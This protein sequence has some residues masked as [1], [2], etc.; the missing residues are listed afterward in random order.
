MGV[1]PPPIPDTFVALI[2]MIS[3]VGT[4]MGDPWALPNP[5]EVETFGDTMSLLSTELSY[6]AIQSES[7]STIF[8]QMKINLIN[9]LCLSGKTSS[10]LHHMTS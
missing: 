2:N 3:S 1:F 8:F 9:T 7:E 4:L 5:A 6:S 10:P